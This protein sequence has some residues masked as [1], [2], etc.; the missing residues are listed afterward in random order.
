MA[1]LFCDCLV[2]FT[3]RPGATPPFSASL[4]ARAAPSGLSA[5]TPVTDLSEGDDLL[6]QLGPLRQFLVKRLVDFKETR[7]QFGAQIR[8]LVQEFRKQQKASFGLASPPRVVFEEG[9]KSALP[10]THCFN[11]T[12][13]VVDAEDVHGIIREGLEG[14][15]QAFGKQ[16]AFESGA[17]VRAHLRSGRVLEF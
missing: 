10:P 8:L 12:V 11:E 14:I 9:C 7:W 4:S 5:P 16:L 3:N 15:A 1:P 2:D 17:E 13:K 6:P